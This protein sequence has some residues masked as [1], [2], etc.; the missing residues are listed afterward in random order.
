MDDE[1]NVIESFNVGDKISKSHNTYIVV[2][3]DSNRKKVSVKH[4]VMKYLC[5][6]E[7]GSKFSLVKEGGHEGC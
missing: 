7:Y 1:L 5:E 4:I 6:F 3:K 2:S